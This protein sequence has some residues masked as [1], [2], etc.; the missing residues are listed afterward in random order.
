MKIMLG[1]NKE[2]VSGV[3]VIIMVFSMAMPAFSFFGTQNAEAGE[4]LTDII[5]ATRAQGLGYDGTGI[6][7]GESGTGL[8]TGD[9]ATVFTDFS[10]RVDYWVDWCES[11]TSDGVAEDDYGMSTPFIGWMAG[12]PHAIVKATD[13][14]ISWE[15]AEIDTVQLAYFPVL[16]IV[17]YNNQQYFFSNALRDF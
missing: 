17:F 1:K 9:N 15:Q 11:D 12:D 14:G 2:I 7:I 6:L 13:G 4:V 8:D 3:I 16:S 10:G 5:G